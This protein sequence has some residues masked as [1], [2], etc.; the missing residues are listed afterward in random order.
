MLFIACEQ[1]ER[2]GLI[3]PLQLV[4]Y[5][6][7]IVKRK[8]GHNGTEDFFTHDRIVVRYVIHN[9]GGYLTGIGL[10]ASA[11]DYLFFIYQSAKS[12]EMLFI[13]DLAVILVFKGG[14]AVLLFDLCAGGFDEVVLYGSL[15]E[16]V[17][18]SN[19]GLTAVKIFSEHDTL[20]GKLYICARVYDTRA[21]SS[22]LQHGGSQML[23]RAAKHL[24]AYRLT[25]REEHEIEFLIEKCGVFSS[26][27][28]DHR[29][30]FGRKA[31]RDDLF[32]DLAGGGGVSAGLHDRRVTRGDSICQG[33]ERQKEGIVPRAHNERVSVRH[34]LLVAVRTK[35]RQRRCDRL[36]FG[37]FLRMFDHIGYLGQH[38]AALAHKALE[39]ALSEIARKRIVD[40]VLIFFYRFIELFELLYA[41]FD[42]NSR[43]ASVIFSLF[44]KQALYFLV[45]HLPLLQSPIW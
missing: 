25:A 28:H 12:C 44:F 21:F 45:C 27:P 6:V 5:R 42:G 36:S 14:F 34:G 39:M 15:A 13:D 33:I 7:K 31:F 18:G 37:K 11:D 32:Y 1:I 17:V 38:Q 20:C 2:K 19:A 3:F 24:L 43:P 40:F 22:K 9:G 8:D 26:A 30:V 23:C 35:L 10:R 4:N 16:D 29:Y 41:E